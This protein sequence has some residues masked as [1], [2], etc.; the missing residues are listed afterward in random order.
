MK[1]KIKYSIYLLLTICSVLASCNDDFLDKQ[2]TD[3]L[4]QETYWVSEKNA[5]MAVTACYG[6][7]GDEWWTSFLTCATDDSYAWSNW[8]CDMMYVVD[9]SATTSLGTFSHFWDNSYKAIAAANNVVDNI[10]A[11]PDMNDSTRARLKAEARFCRDYAYQHLIAYYGDVPLITHVQTDPST[12]D[13]SRTPKDSIVDFIVNDIDDFAKDLP[14]SYDDADWGRATRG[15]ALALKARTLL[16][17]G[18]W[19]KAADAAKQIMDMGIYSIDPNYSS[20]FD[21]SNENSNEIIL[22]AQYT[23]T[24]KSSLATWIG[25]PSLSGWAE[26]VPLQSLVDAYECTDGKSIDQSSLYDAG[27]PFKN[28]DPRLAM[29]VILPGAEV[30]GKVIDVTAA[31]SADALGENNASYS[32]YYYKKYVPTEISGSYDA[33]CTNDI[34]LFRYAGVLLTYAEAKIEANDIDQSVYD[35]INAVRQRSDVNMPAITSGKTQDELRTIVRHERRVEFPMEEERFF[36]IRRWK[37]AEDVIPGKIYGIM[38]DYNTDRSDYGSHVLVGARVFDAGRD[39]LW[40]VP[41]SE[42]DLNKNL[43]QN[44]GW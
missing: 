9:G 40:P 31:G 22:S 34:I 24:Y 20:L 35:A 33:N 42:M 30:N 41:Q 5:E 11:V 21:G 1:M 16:F 7:F 27:H 43:T 23:S 14:E 39:Y 37:I 28:R 4:S 2:R 25:A 18:Q 17:D 38:N 3:A 12:Y 19:E 8:P 15:A 6:F 36:D 44:P 26:V 10:D 29:T 13:V 32:G